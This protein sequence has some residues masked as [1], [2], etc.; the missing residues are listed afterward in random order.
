MRAAA[1]GVFF[2]M[3][4]PQSFNYSQ[5]RHDFTTAESQIFTLLQPRNYEDILR[6]IE[7]LT[8]GV[9]EDFMIDETVL[10]RFAKLLKASGINYSK[11]LQTRATIH[12]DP[13]GVIVWG[14][15]MDN[16]PAPLTIIRGSGDIRFVWIYGT[17]EMG[18]LGILKTGKIARGTIDGLEM[19]SG[20]ETSGCFAKAIIWISS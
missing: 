3:T 5:G 8:P 2:H 19:P 4:N 12:K 9:T 18:A 13:E 17:T 15:P 1:N 6:H 20:A 14:F 16:F 11:V 10:H 7:S